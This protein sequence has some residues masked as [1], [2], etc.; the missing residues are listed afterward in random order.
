MWSL[1]A[2]IHGKMTRNAA[3]CGRVGKNPATGAKLKIPAKDVLS[4]KASKTTPKAKAP[5]KK[6]PAKATKAPVKKAVA[7]K[8]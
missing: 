1:R 7:K 2:G 3:S 4:F 6:A 5:A 8:K